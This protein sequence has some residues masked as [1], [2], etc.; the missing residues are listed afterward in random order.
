MERK[1][2]TFKLLRLCLPLFALVLLSVCADSRSKEAGGFDRIQLP[3]NLTA[4]TA[5]LSVEGK[6]RG[7]KPIYID[8]E[9]IRGMPAIS[10]SSFDPW[11]EVE[12]TYTGVSLTA[13]LDYLGGEELGENLEI[14]AANDYK[15]TIKIE[16][17]KELEYILCYMVD[18]VLLTELV[19]LPNKGS[20]IIA[21]FKI[22]L[23]LL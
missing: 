9:S 16:D 5:D 7:G 14:I 20:L 11:E 2:V 3:G 4:E 6:L 15:I 18:D 8:L 17:I 22:H 1:S 10:F 21:I 23:C 19:K 12:H 13:L